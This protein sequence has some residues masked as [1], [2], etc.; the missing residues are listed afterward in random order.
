MNIINVA[1]M[2]SLEWF[3]LLYIRSIK[4]NDD[5]DKIEGNFRSLL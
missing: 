3:R 4:V 1:Y 2:W 5:K